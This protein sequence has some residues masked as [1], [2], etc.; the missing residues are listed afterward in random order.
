MCGLYTGFIILQVTNE[1]RSLLLFLVSFKMDVKLSP[2]LPCF[3][4][5]SGILPRVNIYF[6]EFVYY[7]KD[8]K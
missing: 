5:I 2:D 8:S 1:S 7:N 6:L 3:V 4:L